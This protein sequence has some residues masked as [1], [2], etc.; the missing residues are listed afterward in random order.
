M[1][2]VDGFRFY[3]V[4]ILELTTTVFSLLTE[5]LIQTNQPNTELI[6]YHLFSA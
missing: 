3:S 4:N 5:L 2:F 1:L 6:Y